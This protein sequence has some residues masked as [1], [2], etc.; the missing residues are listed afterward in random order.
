MP[1]SKGATI[2]S[3]SSSISS[4]SSNSIHHELFTSSYQE[5]AQQALKCSR[6]SMRKQDDAHSLS[7]STA[8]TGPVWPFLPSLIGSLKSKPALLLRSA[9]QTL[10]LWSELPLTSM[11][12]STAR[13][14]T[15]PLCSLLVATGIPACKF[16]ILTVRSEEPEEAGQ[17]RHE[18][19]KICQA[20][21]AN[22]SA[23]VG[24]FAHL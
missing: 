14:Q 18:W 5:A 24:N 16:Q 15:L 3:S 22:S 9:S 13:Q 4:S 11:F 23:R 19:R 2:S 21:A 12:S 6:H 20:K 8:A 1:V 17:R 7:S 10:S